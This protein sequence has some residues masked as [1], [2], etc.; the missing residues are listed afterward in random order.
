[1]SPAEL[2]GR[3]RGFYRQ[4]ESARIRTFVPIFVERLV[5]RSVEQPSQTT[6]GTAAA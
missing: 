5:R 1:M 2:E 4:F 3:V 6:P